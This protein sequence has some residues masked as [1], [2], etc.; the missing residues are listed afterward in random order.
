MDM[1]ELNSEGLV[2][3]WFMASGLRKGIVLSEGLHDWGRWAMPHLKSEMFLEL[4]STEI[5]TS[6][7]FSSMMSTDHAF[8]VCL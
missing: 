5:D 8:P 2:S 6:R 4:I 1:W 3:F 7:D